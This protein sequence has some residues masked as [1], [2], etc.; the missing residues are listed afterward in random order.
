MYLSKLTLNIEHPASKRALANYY[1]AH[2]LLWRGFPDKKDG[3]SPRVLFRVENSPAGYPPVVLVQS[4]LEPSWDPLLRDGVLSS[5]QAKEFSPQFTSGQRLRFRLRANP[6][7]KITKESRSK[8][9]TP[10]KRK[11]RVGLF[12]EEKQTA[13]LKR[14]AEAGGFCLLDVAISSHGTVTSRKPG[15]RIPITHHA[16]T[17]YGILEVRDPALF[18]DALRAGIGSAKAFGFGLLSLARA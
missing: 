2:R 7:K 10:R 1:E 3:G 8:D 13:W 17:F 12:G 6:T 18:T 16:V 15:W 11:P 9:G 4:D 14:K 5:A